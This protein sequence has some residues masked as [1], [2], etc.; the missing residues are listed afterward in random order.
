MLALNAETGFCE[1]QHESSSLSVPKKH[2]RL[3]E[4]SEK[5]DWNHIKPLF[6]R[7]TIPLKTER[8][9]QDN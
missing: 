4:K 3:Y 9:P 5:L 2:R 6:F 7:L 8:K 1:L